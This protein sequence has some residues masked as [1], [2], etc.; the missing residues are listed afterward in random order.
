MSIAPDRPG[1]HNDLPGSSA[2]RRQ[3]TAAPGPLAIGPTENEMFSSA[4]RAASGTLAPLSGD[5]RGLVWLSSKRSDEL[6]DILRRHPAIGW[7]QL[8]WAG[9]DGFQD[10]FAELD[11]GTAPIFTSAKGAY[12]EPVAE[13]ALALTLGLQRE[14]PSKSRAAVW[15]TERTGLSLFRNNVVI[16]GAGGITAELLRLLA[17]FRVTTTVVRRSSEPCVGADRTVTAAELDSVLPDADVLV[18]AAASTAETRHIIGADQLALMPSHAV[19]VNIARGALLDQDA[20]VEALQSDRLWGAGLDV[21]EPE[22]L[23]AD[24]AL[25]RQNRCV[26]TSHSADTAL[27]TAHLLS[28]RIQTNVRS[29]LS[30]QPFLGLVDTRAGY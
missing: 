2:E 30:G 6:S 26:I 4:I 29:F 23:P 21:S 17:P 27:M 3:R 24:H 10:L 5:T 14:I 16:V 13:H 18:L 1:Q 11:H 28:S 8:P 12:S 15:Q 19:L 7:V 20:L 25:W 9:V 22:P